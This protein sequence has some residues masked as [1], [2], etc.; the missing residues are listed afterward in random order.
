MLAMADFD[1]NNNE[2]ESTT[3]S[4]GSL[5]SEINQEADESEEYEVDQSL[6]D[7][8]P[9]ELV[10][11]A[12]ENGKKTVK[13]QGYNWSDTNDESMKIGEDNTIKL[14]DS[15][16]IA[17]HIIN[18]SNDEIENEN[19]TISEDI[20]ELMSL[21]KEANDDDRNNIYKLVKYLSNIQDILDDIEKEV[22]LDKIM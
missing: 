11:D 15:Y 22:D 12:N 20:Q 13:I 17:K 21:A 18:L 7:H 4:A 3:I 14:D 10:V 19:E 5:T 9:K 2:N 1:T 6:T 16:S 8:T